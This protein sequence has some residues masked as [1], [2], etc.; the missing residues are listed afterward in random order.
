MGEFSSAIPN[1][2]GEQ[3]VIA[4]AQHIVKALGASKNLNDDLR[5][6]LSQLDC[7]L[8]AMTIITTESRGEGF[9]E[10][11]D[12]L[13][14]AQEKIMSWESRQRDSDLIEA[15]EYLKAVD[16][17]QTVIE[18]LRS[19]SG[20]ENGKQKELLNRADSILQMAM[21]RL[22]EEV[23]HILVQHKQ[24]FEPKYMSFRSCQQNVVVYDESFVS[25]EDIPLEEASW[26]SSSSSGI[27][28]E[29]YFVDLI[30]PHVIPHL[31]S[32]ANVMFASNYHQEFCQAF[33]GVRKDALEEY[34]VILKMENFSIEDVLKM[35]WRRLN[36]EIKKWIR[37]MKIITRYLAS[38]KWLC[39]RILGDFGF[40]NP[41]C[42]MQISKASLLHLLN[43][44]AAIAMGTHQPEKLF[45]LLD[46]Y[47][48]VADTL[49]DID[50][51][52]LEEADTCVTI[53]FRE[54]LTNLGDSAKA[55]FV[56]FGN[57]IAANASTS[58]FPGGGI[59]HLTR[60]VMN[61]IKTL[62]IYC[63]TLNVLLRSQ[64]ADVSNPVFEPENGQIVSSLTQCPM[65]RHLR[66]ITSTLVF[67]L[68]SK[69][70][71]YK[72]GAL[73]HIFLMNNIHYIVQKVKGSELGIFFGDKWIRDHI[74]M[75][76]Q[77]A[78]SYERATWSSVLS[79]VR[80]DGNVGSSSASKANL[81]ERCRG[82]SSAFE[83]V[84]RN[85]TGW[86]IPDI[87]LRDDLQ[88]S[89]S[90]KVVHAYRSFIGRNS[91]NLSEKYIKYSADDLQNY[92]LDLFGGSSRS[93]HISRKK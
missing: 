52:F 90:M 63:N 28:S 27:E 1:C 58:P 26:R 34:F 44:G 21:S 65:A 67:K 41:L 9:G 12:R 10:V 54:L 33:I 35:E 89:T 20:N 14:C 48:V 17:V 45:S 53:E 78:T 84:Y 61:Y 22:E 3:H 68:D 8:S 62:P 18:G 31:K 51:L 6:I 36:Y 87:Q 72:D 55:T 93:L 11:E 2:E 57:A 46:M 59:H 29:N 37:S 38:E 24:Y 86:S 91:A 79:L 56:A 81:K 75:F 60:Y 13:K 50:S 69:S 82:F 19:L 4:A 49:L 70:K 15:S 88:I 64:D 23:I 73:Q 66:S 39:D 71:L 47:E 30:H 77:H 16:E 74:R 80:E 43:F 7:H 40:V 83:E 5:K 32:I 85:Q 25:V 92:I 76:R 42:F